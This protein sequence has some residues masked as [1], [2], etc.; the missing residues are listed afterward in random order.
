MLNHKGKRLICLIT[1]ERYFYAQS[2]KK[3]T[4]L[5]NYKELKK[6]FEYM[7]YNQRCSQ[8]NANRTNSVFLDR[9]LRILRYELL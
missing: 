6:G 3:D 1:K 9:H 7:I 4:S 5:N 2:Q 8:N